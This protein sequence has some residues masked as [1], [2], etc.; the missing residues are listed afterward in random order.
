VTVAQAVHEWTSDDESFEAAFTFAPTVTGAHRIRLVA[1]TEGARAALADTLINVRDQALRVLVYEAR[2]TWP[3][4]FV[5]RTLAAD[6]MFEVAATSRSSRPAATIAGGA[7]PRLDAL[8]ADRYDAVV[9]GALDELRPEDLRALDRFASDRGGT[10]VLVPDR[11]IPAAVSRAFDL[12]E[13]EETLLQR[14]IA[15]RQA[16]APVRASELLLLTADDRATT[17][18]V[19]PHGGGIRP[20]VAAFQRGEGQVV[21]SGL[22]DA[23][24]F[25]GDSNAAFDTFWRSLVADA[26]LAARPPVELRLSPA[27]ARPG[28]IVHVAL[29]I[30]PSEFQEERNLV[31]VGTV[32]AELAGTDGTRETIRLWPGVRA[33]LFEGTIP[34]PAP[35]GYTVRATHGKSSVEVPLIAAD[36]VVGVATDTQAALA[37]RAAMTGG[38]VA[39][40][41]DAA[42]RAL[43]AM[44]A[45]TIQR[46]ARPMR[47]PW[48]ILPFATLLCAEWTLRRRAGMR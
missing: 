42:A 30:R 44:E 17:I 43:E 40:S 10:V 23:W 8:S 2:P 36:D 5:R 4:T 19:V 22:L 14:P 20:V 3:A 31:T 7:P 1:E 27:T 38:A 25:R 37:H 6:A 29:Q 21:V 46:T 47:S 35:G 13:A 45:G 15:V 41:A 39:A 32:A 24:R 11:R 9:V 26:A 16:A 12:P 33:G 34:A 18:A 28:D 48:W